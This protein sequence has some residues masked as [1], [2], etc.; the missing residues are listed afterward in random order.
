[1]RLTVTDLLGDINYQEIACSTQA[2][3]IL[4]GLLFFIK[5]LYIFCPPSF[6][7]FWINMIACIYLR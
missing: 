7:F 2:R 1:M 6:V 3:G 5:E 4:L